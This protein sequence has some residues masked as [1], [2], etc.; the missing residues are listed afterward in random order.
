MFNSTAK[1]RGVHLDTTTVNPVEAGV[2]PS[3]GAAAFAVRPEWKTLQRPLPVIPCCARGR[4][5]S[6][7]SVKMHPAS[8]RVNSAIPFDLRAEVCSTCAQSDFV[9]R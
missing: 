8:R 4:A 1:H 9:T 7:G 5:H 6:G 3:P 2:R